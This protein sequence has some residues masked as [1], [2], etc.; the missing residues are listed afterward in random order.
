MLRHLTW[1]EWIGVAVVVWLLIDGFLVLAW[2]AVAEHH[3]HTAARRRRRRRC[4][5]VGFGNRP[6]GVD[7]GDLGCFDDGDE[8]YD[9]YLRRVH[10]PL[11]CDFPRGE[12]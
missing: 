4:G 8:D 6:A 9:A 5:Y 10:G 1:K 7:D 12:P 3:R 2:I 11:S